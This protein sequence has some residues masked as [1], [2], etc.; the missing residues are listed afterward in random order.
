ETGGCLGGVSNAIFGL[1]P[2][3]ANS[4]MNKGFGDLVRLLC[5]CMRGLDLRTRVVKFACVAKRGDRASDPLEYLVP[6]AILA[7]AKEP[8]CGIPR[9][10]RALQQPAPV[11]GS[12]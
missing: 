3:T 2:G 6:A 7:L 8:H 5:S 1:R 9:A 4:E 11:G 12:G 10:V